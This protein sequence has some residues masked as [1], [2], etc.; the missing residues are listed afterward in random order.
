MNLLLER[1]SELAA[2]D[3]ALVGMG[4]VVL[5]R[6][7]PGIGKTRLVTE[8]GE[9]AERAGRWVLRGRGGE[10]ERDFAFGVVRQLF[11]PALRG[12]DGPERSA[13]LEG[14]A[15]LAAPAVGLDDDRDGLAVGDRLFAVMHGLYWL[16]ANLASRRPLVLAVDDA[17]WADEQSLRWLA[18]LARR[19]ADVP[20]LV[21]L[22][23]RVKEGAEGSAS[24][25]AI[26][27]EPLTRMFQ[28]RPLS[29]VGVDAF[30]AAVLGTRPAP[31]VARACHQRSA[32]N[33]FVLHELTAALSEAGIAPDRP[34][35]VERV[36][37]LLPGTVS[38]SV[39]RRLGRLP[40][41]A[42]ALARALSV[43]GT[44]AQL[45]DA[46]RLAELPDRVAA[47]AFDALV[48]AGLLLAGMPLRF[49][50]PLMRE[51]IYGDLPVGLRRYEHRRAAEVLAARVAPERI[52][53]HLLQC[54]P[55]RD[56]ESVAILRCC[57]ARAVKRGAPETAARYLTRALEEQPGPEVRGPLLRELGVAEARVGRAEAIEHLEEAVDL[58]GSG[59]EIVAATRELALGLAMLGRM[60]EAVAALERGVA[61]LG[62]RERELE[63]RLEGE[64]C[65]IGQLEVSSTPR[66]SARLRRLAPGLTGET[67][68]ERLVLASYAHLRSVE[69]APAEEL[70]DLAQRALG[71]GL[72]LVE[73]SADSP[74]FYLLMYVFE[75]AGRLDLAYRWLAEA[76]IEARGRG[77]LL[78]TSIALAVRS[79]LR[80]L[81]GELADA[82]ADAR[83]SIDAQLEA[84]WASVLPL[85]VAALAECLLER[86]QAEAAIRLF[87]DSRLGGTLP[88]Q[89]MYR[90][91]QA[92]R[93]RARLAGGLADQG[94]ADL[95]DCEREQMG[96]LASVALLWRT[97]AA[98]ALAA[99]GAHAEARRLAAEQLTLARHA[100]VARPLGV[101][102][103]TIGLLSEGQEA[104]RLLTEA[105]L[106]LAGSSARLEHAR[107]L[108]ELGAAV[109]RA[110][111]RK[112]AREH[113][114]AGYELARGCGS[115]ELL[116]RAREEL[117][118][119]GVRLRRQALTG[120][121]S[122]T[123]SQR[124]VAE[125]AGGGMSNP[126]IAQALFVT[127]K[128]IEMH[129]GNAYRK[130]GVTGREQLAAALAADEGD[131]EHL[132][133]G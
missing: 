2:V 1:E 118:A 40:E 11:E 44:D 83:I 41:P 104:R 23:T 95:L 24:L 102:L 105:V 12:L 85:A 3:S 4:G 126:S 130:L 80:W 49:V 121:D 32:G 29:V 53:A 13:A 110:G 19:L 64:L 108:I 54:E 129:L 113:L 120:A 89:H 116:K 55:Q 25:Q 67:L 51:A 122:L 84:G 48:G 27:A 61:A 65:A 42:A 52:S 73:Q 86:G 72:L 132:P 77:S 66:V 100:N 91:A 125:M 111:Q 56:P 20:V 90:W 93:G 10:L 22:A 78:G 17:H 8:A 5:V 6:G 63:L 119:T 35:A 98:L 117:A 101:A 88:E 46:A 92:S 14:A 9:R 131:R 58:L 81:A 87:E 37:R 31:E 33:P 50:H 47:D 38:R 69:L 82:E 16:C 36:E 96:P 99:T 7:E 97:D 18:Y 112:A 15:A 34:E 74:A 26:A 76:L 94:L 68:G 79:Q 114:S 39:L 70:L 75:R 57:A 60:S 106:V 127:R 123:P 43:L 103:R 109:R 107:A 62:G 133:V 71:D 128:T 115:P 45:G 124:R 28:P 59:A 30:L 21:V